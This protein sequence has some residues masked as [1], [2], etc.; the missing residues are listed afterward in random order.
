M[1]RKGVVYK[2]D[3]HLVGDVVHRLP[4]RLP[5]FLKHRYH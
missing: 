2:G 1:R 5:T 4:K 3:A